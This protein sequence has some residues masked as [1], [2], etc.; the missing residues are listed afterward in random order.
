VT[1]NEMHIAVNLGVQKIASFQVDNFLSEEVDHELNI[2]MDRFIKQRYNPLSNKL[3]KGFEQSQKRIDDLRNLV[4]VARINSFQ[5]DGF[6]YGDIDGEFFGTDKVALPNDYMFLVNLR[7]IVNDACQSVFINAEE[8]YFSFQ[9]ISLTPPITGYILTS[10]RTVLY[11]GG[12]TIEIAAN[13]TGLTKDQLLN[14]ETY[15]ATLV[16]SLS[17]EQLNTDIIEQSPTADGNELFLKF[18]QEFY[19]GSLS[20]TLV[21]EHPTNSVTTG[22]TIPVTSV[23]MESA[24][25]VLIRKRFIAGNTVYRKVSCN[26]AQ[27]DDIYTLLDDP[28]N[29]TKSTSPLYTIEENFI[30]F[31]TNQEFVVEKADVQ[32]IRSP[33]RMTKTLGV[34]CELSEHTHQEIVEM[35]VKSI[36]ESVQDARYQSQSVEVTESE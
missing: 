14:N 35:A 33:Q 31:H 6:A 3:R 36:L 17:L 20:T 22:G 19:N 5:G 18:S 29:T 13:T 28:F 21:W 7:A 16:P 30:T 27:L 9:R 23:P 11:D 10:I 25:T 12:D 26:F 2:A 24:E 4:V 34:G 32:Y 8:D 1:I 15:A